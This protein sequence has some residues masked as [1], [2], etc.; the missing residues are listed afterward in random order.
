MSAG[1]CR[2]RFAIARILAALDTVLEI[3]AIHELRENVPVPVPCDCILRVRIE[4]AHG[5]RRDTVGVGFDLIEAINDCSPESVGADFVVAKTP[6]RPEAIHQTG[7]RVGIVEQIIE[8]VRD[9]SR[10]AAFANGAQRVGIDTIGTW[11][12]C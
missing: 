2:V 3:S 7:N 5:A 9:N 8:P 11:L 4:I 10:V 6:G 12:V 1:N